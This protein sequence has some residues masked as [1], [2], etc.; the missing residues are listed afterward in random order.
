MESISTNDG[1]EKF[2]SQT[3][4]E[5]TTS[6]IRPNHPGSTGPTGPSGHTGPVGPVNGIIT[7]TPILNVAGTPEDSVTL[8]VL[9]SLNLISNTLEITVSPG[10][11]NVNIELSSGTTGATGPTGPTGSAGERGGNGTI[12][13]TGPEGSTG[14]IG[15]TGPTGS[16]GPT[17]YVGAMGPAGPI[18]VTGAEGSLGPHGITGST[19][20]TGEAGLI[21]LAGPI[22]EIGATGYSGE[23]GATGILGAMGRPGT[24]G[25]GGP[26]VAGD[27]GP[28]GST[29]ATGAIGTGSTGLKGSTGTTGVMGQSG[30]IG[31][32][33]PTGPKG[34]TGS[35]G[36]T[37]IAGPTVSGA[38][39]EVGPTGSIGVTG[40]V[41]T[42]SFSGFVSVSNAGGQYDPINYFIIAA[43]YFN[44]GTYDPAYS[45]FI[46]SEPGIYLITVTVN[47]S[48]TTPTIT[49]DLQ[50]DA[51]NVIVYHNYTPLLI[52]T[53]PV[54][55]IDIHPQTFRA[56][57]SSGTITVGGVFK[58]NNGTIELEFNS[59]DPNFNV[60]FGGSG[61]GD[62]IT[63]SILQ[64]S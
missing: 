32:T 52:G 53:F 64:I 46:V 25:A 42:N 9:D 5:V 39:G 3:D 15:S 20:T 47:Y 2:S 51:P 24:T 6:G 21:G 54:L 62:G 16:I 28:A 7:G 26:G 37:G 23:I 61:F 40:D 13:P 4:K 41:I 34:V 59:A 49:S 17:G 48:A 55:D 36:P 11:V 35:A 1:F 63:W 57:L 44:L 14:A 50:G 38:T 45:T 10:S 27:T 19:G 12:G 60:N 43:P 22:G 8:G 30:S 29:G 18:G 58:L 56:V 31:S 33:G